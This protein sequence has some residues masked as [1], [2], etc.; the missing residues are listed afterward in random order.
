MSR[1]ALLPLDDCNQLVRVVLREVDGD[2]DP[3]SGTFM[4]Y[5]GHRHMCH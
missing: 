5:D 3:L 2:F 1:R 4:G